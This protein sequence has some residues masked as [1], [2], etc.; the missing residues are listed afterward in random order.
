MGNSGSQTLL[1]YYR[2]KSL[3]LYKNWSSGILFPKGFHS[4]FRLTLT[5]W[6][7]VN[8]SGAVSVRVPPTRPKFLTSTELTLASIATL[9]R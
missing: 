1:R 4:N 6:V 5:G 9:E 7:M 3:D 8:K 2:P